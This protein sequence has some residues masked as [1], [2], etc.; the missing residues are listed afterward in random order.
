MHAPKPIAPI[1]HGVFEASAERQEAIGFLNVVGFRRRW[2][3]VCWERRARNLAFEAPRAGGRQ[4][5]LRF[6]RR[7]LARVRAARTRGESG[8]SA[9][10]RAASRPAFVRCFWSATTSATARR[11]WEP[12]RSDWRSPSSIQRI[13]TGRETPRGTAASFGE[14][15]ALPPSEFGSPLSR[16][17]ACPRVM[18]G[19]ACPAGNGLAGDLRTLASR[20]RPGT[21]GALVPVS[22]RGA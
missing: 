8:S 6:A 12:T 21:S 18:V 15:A 17:S 14:M 4:A 9:T 2:R 13:T 20:T 16:R 11:W 1:Q 5:L 7:A 22:S 3:E 19:R 10:T